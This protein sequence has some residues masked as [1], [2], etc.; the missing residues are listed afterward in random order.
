M[1]GTLGTSYTVSSGALFTFDKVPVNGSPFR[2]RNLSDPPQTS[3][4]SVLYLLNGHT[5]PMVDEFVGGDKE[6]HSLWWF[7]FSS[8]PCVEQ[9]GESPQ[10]SDIVRFVHTN[11]IRLQ[12][13]TPCWAFQS[14][15]NIGQITRGVQR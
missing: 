13:T 14:K 8:W 15:Y 11:K 9:I 3:L 10:I 12:T 6:P 1:D 5:M 7:Q 2:D 4:C